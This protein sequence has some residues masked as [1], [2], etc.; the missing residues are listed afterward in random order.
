MNKFLQPELASP[1][2]TRQIIQDSPIN[3]DLEF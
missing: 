2:P 3:C 1:R